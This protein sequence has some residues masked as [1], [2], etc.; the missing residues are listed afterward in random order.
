MESKSVCE[1]CSQ[2]KETETSFD[3]YGAPDLSYSLPEAASR[4]EFFK[5]V[6]GQDV[7]RHHIKRCPLCGSLYRY[8]LSYEYMM[9]GSEDEETLTRLK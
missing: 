6:E 7:E 8:D 3:K 5:A 9:N 4:L 2:L 1:I